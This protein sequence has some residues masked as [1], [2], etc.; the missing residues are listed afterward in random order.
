MPSYRDIYDRMSGVRRSDF[1]DELERR[2]HRLDERFYGQHNCAD[3]IQDY[4][5]RRAAEEAYEELRQEERRQEERLEEEERKRHEQEL[6]EQ[7]ARERR[8]EE[9]RQ[10]EEAQE[11]ERYREQ[12][13]AE[14]RAEEDELVA[15]EEGGPDGD[16]WPDD[17]EEG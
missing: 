7:A 12:V 11:E 9:E 13:E 16:E 17:E 15:A 8:W 10:Y 5:T 4:S 3:G 6:Q 2:G 14:A 1:R